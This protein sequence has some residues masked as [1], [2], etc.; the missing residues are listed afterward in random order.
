MLSVST[1]KNIESVQ[2]IGNILGVAPN[3]MT[4]KGPGSLPKCK[5][6]YDGK[7]WKSFTLI[8]V[9]IRII[10]AGVGLTEIVYNSVLTSPERALML[11]LIL[12]AVVS[13]GLQIFVLNRYKDV[14]SLINH[15]FVLNHYL[16]KKYHLSS[17]EVM[18]IYK[19]ILNNH[20]T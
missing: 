6:I 18:L 7:C 9:A 3:N 15:F 2:T 1:L 13:A 19:V 12:L 14:N 17:L 20:D 11:L 4:Y 10:M 8:I 16:R 5:V